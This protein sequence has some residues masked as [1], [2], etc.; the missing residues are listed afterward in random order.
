[1]KEPIILNGK[2][3]AQKIR[4]NWKETIS[5]YQI[6]PC[7]AIVSVGTDPASAVYVRNKIKA[8]NEVGITANH[9]QLNEN[10]SEYEVISIIKHLAQDKTVHGIILQLPLPKH[11]VPEYILPHIPPEKDVDGFRHDSLFQ[12]CTPKGVLRLLDTY[13]LTDRLDGSHCVVIGR[14]NIVG[15]PLAK[16][17]LDYNATVS[18]CHSHT[19]QSDLHKLINNADF[20]FSAV[21]QPGFIGPWAIDHFGITM[22]DIGI[23][24]DIEGKLCGDFNPECYEMSYAYTPVPGGIGPMTVAMLI[25]NTVI[26]CMAQEG[27]QP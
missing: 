19:T 3:T 16:M 23:N 27:V 18:I 15:K 8:C 5:L 6:H 17:L 11:L 1:M 20:V 2:T 13:S 25:E 26:A 7:L 21:G 9:I 12:P 4:A 10:A 14:S 24:R 22:V